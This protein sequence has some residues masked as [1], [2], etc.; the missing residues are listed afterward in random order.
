ML[1][2]L[3]LVGGW[4]GWEGGANSPH[5]LRPCTDIKKMYFTFSPFELVRTNVEK[6]GKG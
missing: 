2:L 6:T 3:V 4:G 1:Y 5:K